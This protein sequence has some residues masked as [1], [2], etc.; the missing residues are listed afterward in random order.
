MFAARRPLNVLTTIGFVKVWVPA[1]VFDVVV[2]NAK[3]NTPVELL[4]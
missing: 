3:E 2:P 4:Y 1:Q